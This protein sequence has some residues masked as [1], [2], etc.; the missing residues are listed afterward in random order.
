MKRVLPLLVVVLAP[1]FMLPTVWSDPL[2]AGEDDAVFFHP[3]RVL[4]GESIARG[5]WPMA[6]PLEATGSAL[7]GDPQTAVMYPPTWLFAVMDDMLAYSISILLAFVI[8]GLGAYAYLRRLS[9]VSVAATVGALAFMF[10]GFMVGHRVHL[11]MIHTAAFFPWVLWGI[12]GL[13]NPHRRLRSAF[14]LA[15]T[16]FLAI[17][18]GH[19]PILVHMSL[20]WGVYF[21][22]RARPLVPALGYTAGAG[23][24]ALALAAPQLMASMDLLEQAT[25]NRL[26]YALAG[27]NSFFPAALVLQLFPFLTG[28]R[29]PNFFEQPWWGPGHLC[30]QLGYVGL[31]TLVLA[32][33]TAMTIRR[34]SSAAHASLVRCWLWMG[35]GAFLFMLGYYLPTYRLI[36]ALPILGIVR[37]P[38]R[39]VLVL[40]FAL[41]TLAAIGVHTAI[42]RTSPLA[43][44]IRERIRR[45]VSLW[46][47]ATMGLLVATLFVL[48]LLLPDAWAK[49]MPWPMTGGVDHLRGAL[50]PSNPALWVPLV[51]CVLTA[52]A[53]S[54]WS[55]APTK[56]AWMIVA[57]LL[58]DLFMI[59][60]FVDVPASDHPTYNPSVSSA[61]TW[62]REQEPPLGTHI[63]SL[64]DTRLKRPAERVLP[65]V[66]HALGVSTINT[67]GPFQSPAHAHLFEFRLWGVSRSWASLLRRNHLLSLYGVKYIIA[68]E[69]EHVEVLRS[70]KVIKDPNATAPGPELLTASWSFANAKRTNDVIALD[71]ASP[72]S[73]ATTTQTVSLEPNTH[74]RMA[75]DVRGPVDGAAHFVRADFVEDFGGAALGYDA[76]PYA[77][78]AYDDQIGTS[79]RHFEWD[80]TTPAD[81]P[82]RL[83][84]RVASMGER[85]IELRHISLRTHAPYTPRL[86]AKH[87]H[88]GL[89]VYKDVASFEPLHPGDHAVH[90]F[91][92]QLLETNASRR[93]VPASSETIE[94]LKWRPG[95]WLDDAARPLPFIGFRVPPAPW[96]AFYGGTVPALVLLLV[97]GA[98]IYWKRAGE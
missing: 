25:R 4:V 90:I 83:T 17:A 1:L 10:G 49:N 21:L 56:R 67:Y 71:E 12:E 45:F 86:N 81:V 72:L 65:K 9:L 55:R 48:P 76:N 13:R 70:V 31:V 11:S 20:A 15:I 34:K 91:E 89:R 96:G 52:V 68:S 40:T 39:M 79:W 88:K 92:N 22:V 57:I 24:V 2:S 41:A 7:M 26:G 47:P 16:F 85:P 30:E 97:L 84:F 32:G 63:L 75:L 3:I 44:R 38:S 80:F 29:T 66:A 28:S 5:E 43:E 33:A 51:L 78:M 50:S 8:A 60:R 46:L 19:W 77:L 74:Y 23:I 82:D 61:A 58:M 62:L 53:V 87:E 94:V 18:A 73:P 42:A 54:L 64:T 36:H 35:I 93:H 37:C 69:P 27:E 6:N 59:T 14:A 95:P 98:F